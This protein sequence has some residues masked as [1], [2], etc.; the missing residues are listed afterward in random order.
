MTPRR[1]QAGFTVVELIVVIVVLGILAGV[2][3]PRLN[4][5]APEDALGTRDTVKG[6]LRL[7]QR[8]A[9]SKQTGVCL[10]RAGATTVRVVYGTA[11]GCNGTPLLE[12]GTGSAIVF[13]APGGITLSGAAFVR[14]DATGRPVSANGGAVLAV[15]S[16]INVNTGGTASTVS[17]QPQTG[18][19]N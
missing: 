16:V 18:F 17:V 14:F 8:L 9:T 13:T 12:P 10:V 19:V 2:A 3:L 1:R 11:G 15:P 6:L 5:S 4:N 7:A